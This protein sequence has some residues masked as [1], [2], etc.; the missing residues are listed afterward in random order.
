MCHRSRRSVQQCAGLLFL[1]PYLTSAT[2]ICL[3]PKKHPSLWLSK[4]R[5]SGERYIWS[6]KGVKRLRT[7]IRHVSGKL[8]VLGVKNSRGENFRRQFAGST[9]PI[10]GNQ[11]T[12][13]QWT[14]Q[15]PSHRL[16]C[17][18]HTRRDSTMASERESYSRLESTL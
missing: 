7:R 5:N 16:R 17:S 15:S 4:R 6:R 18:L 12:E 10:I 2:K 11:S 8:G 1:S 9:G 14:T 3:L 13:E